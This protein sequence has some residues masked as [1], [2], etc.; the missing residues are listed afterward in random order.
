MNDYCR[1]LC[2]CASEALCVRYGIDFCIK[3]NRSLVFLC[4]LRS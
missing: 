2:N 3:A 1:A 4:P